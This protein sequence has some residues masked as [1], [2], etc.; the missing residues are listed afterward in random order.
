MSKIPSEPFVIIDGSSYLFRAYHALPP[1]TNDNDHPTGAMF[2]VISMLRNN[3]ERYKP[4]YLAMVFDYKGP[5]FRH[6]LYPEYK[7]N[8]PA[9][10]EDLLIQFVP[11]NTIIQAMGVKI[12]I[13]PK[14]EADDVIA[15]LATMAKK[16]NIPTIISTSDK[17]LA[18]L[19]DSNTTLVNTMSD[20][21][22]DRA[23][24]FN[25]FAV[26]PEQIV[27]YLTLIGDSVDNIPGVAKCGPKTAVKWLQE[28][29]DLDNIINNA[30]KIT[31][32]VGEYL[33]QAVPFLPLYKELILLRHDL[34]LELA[35]EDFVI[36]APNHQALTKLYKEYNFKMWLKEL[37]EQLA[38]NQQE[39]LPVL[40]LRTL[41]SAQELF[42][43]IPRDAI[44]ALELRA[45]MLAICFNATHL[46]NIAFEQARDLFLNPQIT[47]VGYD[48][49]PLLK[50]LLSHDIKLQ[51][52]IFDLKLA[53]YVL[54]S[55]DN[56]TLR[57]LMSKYLNK[58]IF[59]EDEFLG[60][61]LPLYAELLVIFNEAKG[62]QSIL[63][64][65]EIP[66]ILV[67]AKM[68]FYGVFIDVKALQAQSAEISGTL[69]NLELEIFKL[70][71]QEFNL[72]SPKQ[73]QE[74][75]FDKLGL[76]IIKKT[77]KGQASTDESV[78]QELSANF[79]LPKLLLHYRGLFKLKSTYTD[80]LPQDVNI[81][82][83][84]VHTTYQQTVTSTGRLSSVDPNLQNIPIKTPEGRKIRQAFVAPDDKVIITADYSQIELRILAHLS[85]DPVLLETFAQGKDIHAMTASEV[86]GV[87]LNDVTSEQR[88]HAK[89]INFGLIYGMGSVG[90]SKQL[91]VSRA[92]AQL[93]IDAYFQRFPKVKSFM[94]Q[95]K[96]FAVKNGYVQTIFG[97]RLYLADI[98]SSNTM[99]KN[100]A[101]RAAINAPMQGAQADIIKLAMIKLDLWQES[102]KDLFM[103]MQ[104][105][106]ELVFETTADNLEGKIATIKQIMESAASLQTPLLVDIGAGH[107]W[108][109]A[110]S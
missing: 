99:L 63:Y 52:K 110:K 5:N 20:Y 44:I 53:A 43:Q 58:D 105:H 68:E 41:N 64:D 78:L 14:V 1:L 61:F 50:K 104:V 92:D 83:G 10:P 31:G 57:F 101:E 49:K 89:V 3:I 75:M 30:D 33:R 32:K 62:L 28:Y 51:A 70:A 8:R 77:P 54:N 84:R 74:I 17:D 76:P 94:E 35:I 86:F 65:I 45:N 72:S 100:A 47:I 102:I 85:N 48:L 59:E 98:T 93:Y 12:I 18:Q 21:I 66:M 73:L 42:E 40:E 87:N 82:T 56:L 96:A 13:I 95:T 7:A 9:T 55:T 23:G 39:P 38:K 71:G 90:L 103:I 60:L 88:R 67:L 26:N 16:Q 80:R 19:V 91:N 108:D 22:M 34:N 81:H 6:E 24:V 69:K 11:L 106:D 4:K 27:D 79:E 2:G 97:R 109:S 36:D 15:T 107:S 46:Y 37:E 25:K 29:G